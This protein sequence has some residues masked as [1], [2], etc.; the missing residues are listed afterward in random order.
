MNRNR[1]SRTRAHV[2]ALR[3]IEAFYP[4]EEQMPAHR[5]CECGH[6]DRWHDSAD[7]G[8]F[9]NCVERGCPCRQFRP[10]EARD[11]AA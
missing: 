1:L 8:V 6:S 5:M 4:V 11:A 7:I 2:A 9:T 3:D 10:R